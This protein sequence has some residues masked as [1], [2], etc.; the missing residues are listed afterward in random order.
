MSSGPQDLLT[1]RKN[2]YSYRFFDDMQ[3]FNCFV[4]SLL[5]GWCCS[6][7]LCKNTT[8]LVLKDLSLFF[9][10]KFQ[11]VW[12]LFVLQQ[13]RYPTLC[14]KLIADIF[15]ELLRIILVIAYCYASLLE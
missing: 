8:K 14:S 4:R 7:F 5:H 2:F 1:E 15:P 9:V 13:W 6:R 3:I 11:G 10:I 12:I